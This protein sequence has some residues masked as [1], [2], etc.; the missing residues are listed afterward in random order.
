M[1]PH[2]GDDSLDNTGRD[3]VA[4]RME[5]IRQRLADVQG[6]LPAHSIPPAMVMEIEALEEELEQLQREAEQ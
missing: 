6:R 3:Q 5:Q 4:Q 2:E 1:M